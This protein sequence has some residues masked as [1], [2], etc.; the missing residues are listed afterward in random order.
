M[1]NIELKKIEPREVIPG[2]YAKFVQSDNVTLAYWEIKKGSILPQHK[3]PN[4][5]ISNVIKGNF[6]M[7]VEGTSRILRPGSVV[8][9]P[10]STM[11]SGEAL[12]DCFIIDVFY[13]FRK[14]D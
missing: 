13:P 7:K 3:H 4:E 9:I 2:F 8:V 1:K 6:K 11:H 14:S 10:P 5:Q 12:T